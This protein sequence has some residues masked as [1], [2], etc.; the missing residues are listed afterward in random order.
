MAEY[1]ADLDVFPS[2]DDRPDYYV[3]YDETGPFSAEVG[4]GECLGS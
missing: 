4:V 3:D 2:P 1:L